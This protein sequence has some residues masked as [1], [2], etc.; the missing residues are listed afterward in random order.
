MGSRLRTGSVS[1]HVVLPSSIP[2]HV[3]RPPR[4]FYWHELMLWP[5]DIPEHAIV[6]LSANDDLVPAEL[7]QVTCMTLQ[8]K[9]TST[10]GA[11]TL[12]HCGHRSGVCPWTFVAGQ[13]LL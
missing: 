5:K 9:Q 6:A 11:Q 3:S 8:P 10:G 2:E 12:R 1:L 4:R 13:A 7:V